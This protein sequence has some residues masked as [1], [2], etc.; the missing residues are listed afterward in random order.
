MI[1]ENIERNYIKD[2]F[3]LL[4][5]SV[6]IQVIQ[7]IG[8]FILTFYFKKED[9]GLLSFLLSVSVMFEMVV[10][11]QYNNAAIVAANRKN[12]L[13]LMLI[14]V[15]TAGLL[16]GF[17]FLALYLFK[18]FAPQLFANIHLPDLIITLPFFIISNFIFNNG[19][20]LLK[21]FGRIRDINIFRGLYIVTTLVSKFVAAFIFA[22]I[23]SLVYA[24]LIGIIITATIFIFKFRHKIK[25]QLSQLHIKN[26]LVLMTENYRFPKYSIFSSVVSTA[27]TIC[28]PIMITL[29]FGLHE[30][31]IFYLATIFVFQPLLLILQAIGDA[32]LPKVKV[33][34][35]EDKL[36]LLQ[37]IKTQQIII[38]KLVIP[39]LIIAVLAGE[40]LFPYLL[41]ANWVEI[42]KFIKFQ[43]IFYLFTSIYTP[44]SIVADFMK[45]QQFLMVFN[46]SHFM[47]QFLTLFLLHDIFDFTFV[48]L[49]AAI[50]S[51]IHYGFINFYMLQKLK[52]YK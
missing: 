48:I 11:L 24:Q 21:Y 15:L 28:I 40:F 39:Y 20:L 6:I 52:L 45:K 38:L 49:I 19:I 23:S 27:S 9:F 51:A 50:A 31:G 25:T 30:N 22:T 42:G 5:G 2:I 29:F 47:F 32:F 33:I 4:G 17:L 8:T 10:G 46:I 13:N 43:V 41:P 12:V 1:F 14:S 16:S 3:R 18:S 7:L 36:E 44:F 37:F 35:N 26:S 34:F